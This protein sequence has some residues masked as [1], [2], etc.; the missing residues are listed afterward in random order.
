MFDFDL[1]PLMWLAVF[2]LFVGVPLAIWK[3]IDVI[4]WLVQHV[5]IT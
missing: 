4:C 5:T 1:R 3:I 2:G